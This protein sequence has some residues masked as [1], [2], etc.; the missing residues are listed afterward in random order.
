MAT[1]HTSPLLAGSTQFR[2]IDVGEKTSTKREA[3]ALGTIRMTE[4]AFLSLTRNELPKGNALVLAEVA[5]IQAAKKTS[6][7]IP[8]CHPIGMDKVEIRC[9][10]NESDHCVT[11][12]CTVSAHSKT[13]VEMEALVG[14]SCALLALYDLIKGVDPELVI[15]QIRLNYK[16][17]GKSGEWIH[18][19]ETAPSEKKT[20]SLSGISVSILTVSDRVSRG[21]REDISGGI[22]EKELFRLG[23]NIVNRKTVPDEEEKIEEAI[24]QLSQECELILTTGGTGISPRDVTPE[25]IE[26]ICDRIIPGIGERL[27]ASEK[28]S[29][30]LSRAMAGLLGKTVI[31][32]LPGSP[33]AVKEGMDFL[34]TILPHAL[35]IAQG[36]DH[37]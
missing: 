35:H 1:P 3:Q 18:P 6:E 24:K 23:A 16:R 21:E 30:C 8:L 34:G 17:G 2:M 13:G 29:V 26:K 10:P 5:G 28:G 14:T 11:V 7:L 36:G 27:R 19:W 33:S 12:T 4:Q 9:V 31:I 20:P 15:T 37:G 22:L 25:A 32:A